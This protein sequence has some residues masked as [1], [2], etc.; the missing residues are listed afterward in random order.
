MKIISISLIFFFFIATQKVWANNPEL[1]TQWEHSQVVI[2]FPKEKVNSIYG[3]K[4]K[5]ICF[6][7]WISN[8]HVLTKASCV[9]KDK[10]YQRWKAKH[11]IEEALVAKVKSE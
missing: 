10:K 8:K 1:F 5:G 2:Y 11:F 3:I 6:G 9:L 4:A 7:T